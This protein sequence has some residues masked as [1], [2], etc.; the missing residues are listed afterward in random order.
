VAIAVLTRIRVRVI[1]RFDDNPNASMVCSW[2]SA[3][4][5]TRPLTSGIH[6]DTP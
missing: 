3:C 6:S 4:Q 1:S 5:S 2:S